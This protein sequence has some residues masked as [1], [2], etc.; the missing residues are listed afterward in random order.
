MSKSCN[1]SAVP[2]RDVFARAA[3]DQ[4]FVITFD[5]DFADLSAAAG[6]GGP[7]VILLRLRSPRQA[8]MRERLRST[9]AVTEAAL[10][11]GAIV[12]V[13]DSRS[14]VRSVRS[15]TGTTEELRRKKRR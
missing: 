13:E 1:L 12:I 2:D 6:S 11:S 9:L 3:A 5:L 14:R 8:H 10:R 7:G 15:E 4:R